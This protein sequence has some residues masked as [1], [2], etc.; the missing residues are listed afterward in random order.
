MN[1]TKRPTRYGWGAFR[2][3]HVRGAQYDASLAVEMAFRLIP[4][5]VGS[6][7]F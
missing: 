1:S 7:T 4:T 2:V 5:C 3:P 6:L